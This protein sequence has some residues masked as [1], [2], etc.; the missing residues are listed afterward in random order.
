MIKTKTALKMLSISNGSG[1]KDLK[2]LLKEVLKH[3]FF[4]LEIKTC[5]MVFDNQDKCKYAIGF[6]FGKE[7]IDN[8]YLH[9]GSLSGLEP[10]QFWI[11]LNV[12]LNELK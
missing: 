12:L 10:R 5:R 8:N 11:H 3:T 4:S 1:K 7:E 6:D 9:R 2:K